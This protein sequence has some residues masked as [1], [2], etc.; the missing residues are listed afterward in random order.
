MNRRCYGLVRHVHNPEQWRKIQQ[1]RCSGVPVHRRHSMWQ[2]RQHYLETP[3]IVC[4]YCGNDDLWKFGMRGSVQDYMCKKCGRKFRANSPYKMRFTM[5]QIAT[6]LSLFYD[7]M[8]LSAV[9]RQLGEREAP[10]NRSSV[11]RWVLRYTN[12]ATTLF[13]PLVLDTSGTWVADETVVKIGGRNTWFFDII[14][15]E[16]RFL[17]AS[18]LAHSRTIRDVIGVMAEAFKKGEQ[19]TPTCAY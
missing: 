12:E 9:A 5:E 18:H 17:L 14:H 10:I 2:E 13:D 7:G 3:A 11:Y 16:T 4:P 15:A 8:S 6:A 19:A 1:F